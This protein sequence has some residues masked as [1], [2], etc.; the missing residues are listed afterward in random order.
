MKEV[1]IVSIR[2]GTTI[3]FNKRKNRKEKEEKMRKK[4]KGSE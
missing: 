2:L 1:E 4:E 3:I